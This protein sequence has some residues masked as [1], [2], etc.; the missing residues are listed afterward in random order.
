MPLNV[1][2]GQLSQNFLAVP[3]SKTKSYGDRAFSVCAPKLWNDLPLQLRNSASFNIFK[4]NLKTFLFK[5]VFCL[6]CTLVLNILLIIAILNL[7][8]DKKFCEAL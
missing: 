8:V 5:Y 1:T 6:W 7:I 2:S 4:S 3:F